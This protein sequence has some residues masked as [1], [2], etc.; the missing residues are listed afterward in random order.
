MSSGNWQLLWDELV[1]RLRITNTTTRFDMFPAAYA[2]AQ[3]DQQQL[4]SRVVQL[5]ACIGQASSGWAAI[6]DADLTQLYA[7]H[8]RLA[9]NR[10]LNG[11]GLEGALSPDQLMRCADA[12]NA[13]NQKH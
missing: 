1:G 6:T 7:V 8:T 11:K 9:E 13:A 4:A 5:C 3:A 10:L 2:A 12:A